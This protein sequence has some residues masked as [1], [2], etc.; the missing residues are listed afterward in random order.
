MCARELDPLYVQ[1]TGAHLLW[2]V[3]AVAHS[4]FFCLRFFCMSRTSRE[5]DAAT[6][7]H[8]LWLICLRKCQQ[9]LNCLQWCG[10]V[11]LGVNK[12]KHMILPTCMV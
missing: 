9:I 12:R 7:E 3:S 6:V 5:N 1:V 2:A 11:V 10:G 8:L 4:L